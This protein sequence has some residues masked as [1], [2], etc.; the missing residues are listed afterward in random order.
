MIM[1][2]QSRLAYRPETAARKL[3]IGR[4]S[5]Y[6]LISS[7]ELETVKIGRSRLIPASALERYLQRL[8]SSQNGMARG[9]IDEAEQGR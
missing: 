6:G 9:V 5:L 1:D 2:D 3:D 7:G 4:T 8:V